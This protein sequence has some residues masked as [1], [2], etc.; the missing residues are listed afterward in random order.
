V[1]NAD[2]TL[3]RGTLGTFGVASVDKPTVGQYRVR[4]NR[5]VADCAY[6]ATIGVSGRLW[7]NR[8]SCQDLPG[9]LLHVTSRGSEAPWTP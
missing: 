4:L 1:V 8:G 9:C 6:A 2:G 7:M 3:A 5:S